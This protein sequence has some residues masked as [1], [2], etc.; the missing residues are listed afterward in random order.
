ME[1]QRKEHF[2]AVEYSSKNCFKILFG[3]TLLAFGALTPVLSPRLAIEVYEKNRP[4]VA[5]HYEA[6]GNSAKRDGEL[7]GG[8]MIYGGWGSLI[9]GSLL[10]YSVMKESKRQEEEK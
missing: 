1:S 3:L 5:E 7:M 8:L 6:R 9:G 4:L 10:F 2:E